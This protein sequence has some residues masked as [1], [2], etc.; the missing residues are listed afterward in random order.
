MDQV[1]ISAVTVSTARPRMWLAI[2]KPRNAGVA[3]AG[4]PMLSVVPD[5]AALLL[6]GA[7]EV[8]A[9]SD[10]D[11]R[12]LRMPIYLGRFR[13]STDALKVELSGPQDRSAATREVAESASS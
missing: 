13:Y 3:S 7:T 1:A 9:V 11:G 2:L 4:T 10:V 6:A 5:A 8:T 12:R